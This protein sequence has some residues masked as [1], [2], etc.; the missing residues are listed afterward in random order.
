MVLISGTFLER[1]QL[2]S[3]VPQVTV[4]GPILYNIYTSVMPMSGILNISYAYANDTQVYVYRSFNEA[5][6]VEIFNY[7]Y[8][9]L[10]KL[11]K[12]SEQQNLF[13]YPSKCNVALFGN[14]SPGERIKVNMC[15]KIQNTTLPITNHG[16]TW[17]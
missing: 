7:I 16:K 13:I 14:R 2:Y 8:S 12:P 15:I 17:T 5:V 4:L 11:S 10:S 3:R 9:Y 1:K 6:A